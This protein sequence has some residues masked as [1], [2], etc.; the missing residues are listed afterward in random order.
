MLQPGALIIE[1]YRIVRQVGQ[2]GMG[3]VYEATDIRLR[4]HVALKQMLITDPQYAHAFEHEA[5]LLANL[6]HVRL[7][8]VTDHFS[9]TSGQFLV[10]E[11]VPGDD[12]ATL[13]QQ[14]HGPFPVTQ[15][16][17][18]ADQLLDLL[19]YLH[20]RTPPVLHR[21]I[22]PGNLKVAQDGT[23]MLLDFGIAK[24]S[25]AQ[26]HLTSDH[27]IFGYSED[28]SPLEQIQG[29]GTEA[30]SDLYAVGAT[31]YHLL[32]G[33]LPPNALTRVSSLVN[34][35]PDPLRPPHEQNPAIPQTVSAVLMQALSIQLKH[36]P[37]SA[38]VLRTLLAP[39]LAGAPPATTLTQAISLL[40]SA[41]RQAAQ[42]PIAIGT[43]TIAVRPPPATPKG[44]PFLLWSGMLL[45]V[46][47]VGAFLVLANR[48]GTPVAPPPTSAP[49][50]AT[51]VV[52]EAPTAV[53]PT[54]VP[55]ALPSTPT[56]A[57]TVSPSAT[58]APTALPAWVPEMVEVPVGS[59]LMGSSDAN[60][61]WKG[62]KPQHTLTLPTYWIG[63]TEVT[64]AQFRP[65]VE[66][67]GYTNRDYWTEAG[68]TWRQANN[69]TRPEYWNGPD[70][71][72]VGV[73]WFEAVAYCRWL[74]KQTGIAFRLPTEAEWEKAAR[75]PDG[76][77]WPWGNTWDAKRANSSESGLN[78]PMPVG[79][80]PDGASPYGALDMAGNAWEWC[81][82]KWGKPYPYQ[83]EDEWQAA[84]LRDDTIRVIR[85]GSW[86]N[87]RIY[88]RGA[89][90]Y[91]YSGSHISPRDRYSKPGLRVA[92]S[93]AK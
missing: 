31:L 77:L 48:G 51:V 18:W 6:K 65:F 91:N 59:F 73:S 75:G 35:Q 89:Y 5:I 36:R 7:P 12:L 41:P 21:D 88:V 69:V 44:P 10:M 34:E 20:N 84:Y 28:Y 61:E 85:G 40:G 33:T 42:P 80:Y 1:R 23:L 8:K 78:Q 29:T 24:G 16:L 47:L 11:Y 19:E 81:A 14:Q 71:P 68:W 79:Q 76:L 39:S 13:L 64:N 38:T 82:T 30:R 2:G 3:A 53:Q 66:G 27:S 72:V 43:P 57:P 25:L 49:A 15:V 32:V 55:T 4:L 60:A 22:K 90:R 63:K 67:D 93:S 58:T 87:G 50:V 62:E 54:L 74:S 92:S 17:A 26:T 46:V 52:A 70:Y 9:D 83:L 45:A 56:T 86:D 37:A